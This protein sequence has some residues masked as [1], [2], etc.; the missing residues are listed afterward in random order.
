MQLAV[1]R[2]MRPHEVRDR[3]RGQ[4]RRRR[5][6]QSI[7]RRARAVDRRGRRRRRVRLQRRRRG[8]SRSA[9]RGLQGSSR[10]GLQEKKA[11][12]Q[13][14]REGA[15]ST[16]PSESIVEGWNCGG[17][18]LLEQWSDWRLS[19]CAPSALSKRHCSGSLC[20]LSSEDPS[21]HVSSTPLEVSSLLLRG[22]TNYS[23]F[24]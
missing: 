18:F 12:V 19:W 4:R 16:L 8:A 24:N 9:V 20:D 5:P 22:R 21:H 7:D 17:V 15:P 3:K 13:D 23:E 1:E 2:V 11:G 10:G 6:L 14:E